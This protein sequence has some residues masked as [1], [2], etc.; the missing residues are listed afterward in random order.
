MTGTIR[1]INNKVQEYLE[2]TPGKQSF[3]SLFKKNRC[4]RNIT[5]KKEGAA[6]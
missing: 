5:H 3:G 2:V 1:I 4:T 6:I